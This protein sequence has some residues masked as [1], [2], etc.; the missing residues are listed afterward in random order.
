M[1]IPAPNP[2][3][4]SHVVVNGFHTQA[5]GRDNPT[6][7]TIPVLAALSLL[8]LCAASLAAQPIPGRHIAVFAP[9][10][11][12]APQAAEALSRQFGLELSHIYQH[13]I[14]GFAFAGP[15]QAVR[16]LQNHPMIAY[17]EQDQMVSIASVAPP[18]SGIPTGVRRAGI[19]ESLFE[20][21]LP[22]GASV[23]ARIAILDTGLDPHHPD[24]NIDP[25]G[26]RFYQ[27]TVTTGQGKNRQTTQ[28]IRSDDQW[29]DVHGHGTHVA[30]TA[31]ANGQIFGVAPGA[32]LTSVKVLSDQGNSPTSVVIAGVDWVAEH[33][34]R[35]DVANMSLGGWYSQASNDAVR[36]AVE[37]GVVFTVSAGNNRGDASE[38][39]PA[40]E[41]TAITVSA[42]GD[43]DGFPG[44]LSAEVR[45]C[46][47]SETGAQILSGDDTLACFSNFGPSIDVAAPGVQIVS[48]AVG[49]GYRL[50]SGTS[51]A[52]PH[53]AG[54]VALYIAQNR[55]WLPTGADRP[56]FIMDMV[57]STGWR[58][59]DYGY[60][61][62]DPDEF[63]ESLLNVRALIG[64]STRDLSISIIAPENGSLFEKDELV[65][66]SAAAF[67][68]ADD[69]TELIVWTSER[70][71]LL[72]QGG[73]LTTSLS[74]GV[75]ALTAWITDPVSAFSASDTVTITVGNPNA[76]PPP[77]TEPPTLLVQTSTD[78]SSYSH[79]ETVNSTTF[80]IDSQGGSTVAGAAVAWE[81]VNERGARWTASG[82]TDANGQFQTTHRIN[83]SRDGRGVYT[84][85]VEVTKE[86]YTP[87]S[88]STTFQVN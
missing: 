64:F 85:S 56:P 69:V 45:T 29:H 51:M 35:F 21:L 24:L 68:G 4:R 41:P 9:G 81:M 28:E 31:A 88:H 26:I 20:Q 42:L 18:A 7:G 66:L 40:S 3:C 23:D 46:T 53:V 52:A 87:G 47:D 14:R 16:G 43:F 2:F 86:G 82:Q 71:G 54:A 83:A 27:V 13:S 57:K 79:N 36:S 76:E 1:N 11:P 5:R 67:N 6:P 25:A 70:D 15:E 34:H 60:F 74:E 55:Q 78:R 48:A 49:G 75:H 50:A 17:I 65:T 19:D 73:N 38:R 72:G 77:P 39:S 63:P 30:G 22:G 62:D 32:I 59:G 37:R 61:T 58:L 80:A 10:V 33:A 12:S 84:I 44:G 8:V